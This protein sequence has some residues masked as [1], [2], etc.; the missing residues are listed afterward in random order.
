MIG[1]PPSPVVMASS[2]LFG[3]GRDGILVVDEHRPDRRIQGIVEQ[4]ARDV[5][6]VGGRRALGHHLRRMRPC[7]RQVRFVT[8]DAPI[9][10]CPVVGAAPLQLRR[11]RERQHH[12]GAGEPGSVQKARRSRRRSSCTREMAKCREHRQDMNASLFATSGD[13]RRRTM[14]S[15][16]RISCPNAAGV[17]KNTGGSR[18]VN[19]YSATY[20]AF[21]IGV[22]TG[23]YSRGGREPD[24]LPVHP[25][26]RPAAGLE[27]GRERQPSR[28]V[29]D[30]G[31]RP[32]HAR[33]RCARAL[34]L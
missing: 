10:E 25:R 1:S 22:E 11:Q 24:Q 31:S 23:Q 13:E 6:D 30:D 18:S 26:A 15:Q 3:M 7:M 12:V 8:V 2:V 29:R 27:A 28:P 14:E 9:D 21:A 19:L 17:A 4:R 32:L 20:A 33:R 16:R 5:H 34:A